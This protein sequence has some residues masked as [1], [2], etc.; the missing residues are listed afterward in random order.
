MSGIAPEHFAWSVEAGVGVVTLTAAERKNPLTF[1]SYAELRDTFRE[2]AY[3]DDVDA[4]VITGAG[5]N[6]CSGGDVRDIIGPLT[7]MDMGGPL[8]FT[9]M[10][11]DLVKAIRGCR[12]PAIAAIDG[13]C[14][15]AGAA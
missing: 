11:G 1:A 4:V 13:V 12:Q 2:L 6:F 9:R 8:R 7:D 3:V 5:G 10:T 15:G 14:V